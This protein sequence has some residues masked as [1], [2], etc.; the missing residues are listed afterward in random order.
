MR[1]SREDAALAALAC[2]ILLAA[3]AGPGTTFLAVTRPLNMSLYVN[4]SVMAC[5][6]PLVTPAMAL[7]GSDTFFFSSMEAC[8]TGPLQGSL[9][10]EI[11]NSS[12]DVV[13]S[14]T[15]PAYSLLPGQRLEYNATWAALQLPGNYTAVQCDNVSSNASCASAGFT[16]FCSDGARRC[17]GKDLMVCSGGTAWMPLETCSYLCINGSCIPGGPPKARGGGAAFAPAPADLSVTAPGTVDVQQGLSTM[18]FVKAANNGTAIL[19]NAYL[20]VEA[21]GVNAT[22]PALVVDALVPG[23]SVS[24]VVQVDASGTAPGQYNLTWIAVTDLVARDGRVAVDV[25]ARSDDAGACQDSI[26]YYLGILEYLNEE[27][28]ITQLQGFDVSEASDALLAALRELSVSRE[29]RGMGL[30]RECV[31]QGEQVRKALGDAGVLLAKAKAAP[32]QVITIVSPADF[33][34]IMAIALMVALIVV[35]VLRK[36]RRRA[37]SLRKLPLGL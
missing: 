14:M 5:V 35:I 24:F 21:A 17:F 7:Y 19:R 18:F 22:T 25:H 32:V 30:Y 26:D 4:E 27:A 34:Y 8:G 3:L 20:Y 2:G 28:R 16:I 23:E 1:L 29:L 11:R 13:D 37:R 6:Y 36:A 15:S 9:Y 12:G 10:M 33:A 31:D